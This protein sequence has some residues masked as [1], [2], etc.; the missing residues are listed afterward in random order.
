MLNLYMKFDNPETLPLYDELYNGFKLLA[1][2]R[3]WTPEL[4]D[5]LEPVKHIIIQSSSLAYHYASKIIKRRWPEAEPTILKD[6]YSSYSYTT[7]VMP[8]RWEAAEPIMMQYP[9]VAV[10]YARQILA[11]DPEWTKTP[12]HENGRWPEAEP[13]IMEKPEYSVNYATRVIKGRWKD[14]GK[15]E[16]EEIIM[17]DPMETYEYV[18]DVIDGR[19]LEAEPY[20]QQDEYRWKAYKDL[21]GLK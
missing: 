6:P 15:P 8:G 4:A 18:R 19:W 5:E 3:T 12:G 20:I 7:S 17:K 11:N 10:L 14:I 13:Y 16:A 9:E 2:A 1:T 21:V